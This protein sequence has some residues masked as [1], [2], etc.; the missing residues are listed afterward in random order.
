MSSDQP[1]GSL[2]AHKGVL[3]GF[4]YGAAIGAFLGRLTVG[5]AL[6]VA[7]GYLYD[8]GHFK[9]KPSPAKPDSDTDDQDT[10]DRSD[11]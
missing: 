8:S 9:R 6:C 7:L 11:R 1:F 3:L 5:I 10:D 4:V 2:A